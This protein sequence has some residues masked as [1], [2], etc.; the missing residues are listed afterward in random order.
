MLA[1]AIFA[2]VL[3]A[4]YA[5]W[6]AILKG[7]R[8][9]LHAAEEVQRARI[10]L[11]T[12]EDAFLT[13]EMFMSNIKYYLFEAD[14]SGDMAAIRLTAR[15]PDDFL[16]VRQSKLMDQKVRRVSFYTRPAENGMHELIMEQ[17]PLLLDTNGTV[18]LYSIT[19]ARDVSFFGLSF[20][21]ALKNEWLDEWTKTNQLPR[22]V[23]IGLGLGKAKGSGA[24]NEL[25]YSL[26]ALPSGGVGPDVQ[27]GA[28]AAFPGQPFQPGLTN[29]PGFRGNNPF[30][31]GFPN[32]QR[33]G[34]G[35]IR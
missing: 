35:F 14:T 10:A 19:L 7:S 20:Y 5:C 33:S 27:A 31:R 30:N 4:I 15:L 18:A 23:K 25:V 22:L 32:Q 29:Q 28:A 34:G 3:T 11:R 26:V 8:A 12:L 9:G 6:M 24:P 17:A 16:G 2:M 1:M 21:D 13:T